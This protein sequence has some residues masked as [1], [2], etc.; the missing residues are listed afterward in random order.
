MVTRRSK[1]SS[2][3]KTA[4]R[5]GA[6]RSPSDATCT[7]REVALLAGVSRSAV[8][9]AFTPNASV[10]AATRAKILKAARKLGYQP[11]VMA[12]SLITRHSRLI[13]LIMG[14]WE[15]PYYTTMLRG[16]TEKLHARGYRVMLLGCNSDQDV[17]AATRV[18]MQ[19]RVDGILLVST[20]PGEAAA[21][22]FTRSGGRIVLVN[23]EHGQLPA[24]SVLCD[25]AKVGRELAR[26]LLAAGY[27][28]IALLRGDPTYRTSLLRGEGFRKELKSA[29]AGA[30]VLERSNLLGYAAGRAFV[31]EAMSL[32]SPPDAIVCPTDATAIGVIDGA[33]L[34]QGID[35]PENLG[36]VG[37][38][39]IPAA[40]WGSHELTTVRLPIERMVDVAV[41]ALFAG[42][43]SPVVRT[44]S[45]DGEIVERA[46]TRLLRG[47]GRP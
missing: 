16:F 9:R 32:E 33:R 38:G 36:V 1:R 17:D 22:E 44:V 11:N 13:G 35:V 7:S 30:V 40:S 26:S 37:F 39:D 4:G 3:R 27:E 46:S 34:D 31:R 2:S 15:N 29:G 10:S 6:A 24:T 25:N 21:R 42:A 41:E 23:R 20:A 12:R 19:Y 28:K 45:L 18:L 43:D 5:R 47:D 14:E 8:S